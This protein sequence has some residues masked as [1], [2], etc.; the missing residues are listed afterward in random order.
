MAS[1]AGSSATAI[2]DIIFFIFFF[3]LNIF[4]GFCRSKWILK[5]LFFDETGR[6][7]KCP[8]EKE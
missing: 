3:A 2:S 4:A 5:T 1:I 7:I 6:R 8:R